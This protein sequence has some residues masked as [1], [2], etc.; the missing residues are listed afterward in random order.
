MGGGGGGE[1][2][3]NMR[4]DLQLST[5][6]IANSKVKKKSDQFLS[7]RRLVTK[8]EGRR[9]A[10]ATHDAGGVGVSQIQIR[11]RS[12]RDTARGT[13]RVSAPT[14]AR[15]NPRVGVPTLL[16]STSCPVIDTSLL[17]FAPVS[18]KSRMHGGQLRA[19]DIPPL[20]NYS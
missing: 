14:H 18:V 2:L 4:Q 9:A 5:I 11:S 1:I 19:I 8:I 3:I 15:A 17:P 12:S 13:H 7:F 20:A 6:S 16:G 10:S